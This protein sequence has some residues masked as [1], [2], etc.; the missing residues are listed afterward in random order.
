MHVS[1]VEIE[2]DFLFWRSNDTG[3]STILYY[4]RLVQQ[5]EQ[6]IYSSWLNNKQSY[7]P[8]KN[9]KFKRYRISTSYNSTVRYGTVLYFDQPPL[10]LYIRVV[11]YHTIPYRNNKY[12]TLLQENTKC[13]KRQCVT[14][15][16][17]PCMQACMHAWRFIR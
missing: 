11:P 15:S 2:M 8:R 5:I 9:N 10:L 17:K 7:S 13:R 12:L 4:T 6:S 3:Y 1:E 16:L 14:K